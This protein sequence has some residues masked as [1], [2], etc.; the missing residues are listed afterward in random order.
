ME[1]NQKVIAKI[2]CSFKDTHLKKR[3]KLTSLSVVFILHSHVY[4]DIFMPLLK[5]SGLE[6]ASHVDP[7]RKCF[8]LFD[9]LN[10]YS[11]QKEKKKKHLLHMENLEGDSVQTTSNTG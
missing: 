11:T 4:I 7:L 8:I 6:G 5:H 10:I 2:C 9:Y 3:S 1:L